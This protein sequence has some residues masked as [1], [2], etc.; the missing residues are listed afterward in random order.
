MLN[1]VNRTCDFNC[2]KGLR[3]IMYWKCSETTCRC[4]VLSVQW[5]FMVLYIYCVYSVLIQVDSGIHTVV[6]KE[7]KAIQNVRVEYC[8]ALLNEL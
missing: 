3:I 1:V 8:R 2:D 4:Y 6:K 5:K 7:K